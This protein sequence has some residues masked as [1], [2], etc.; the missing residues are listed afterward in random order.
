MT[1]QHIQNNTMR[2]NNKSMMGASKHM[3]V[4]FNKFAQRNSKEYKKFVNSIVERHTNFCITNIEG[5]MQLADDMLRW[6]VWD[7][8]KSLMQTAGLIREEGERISFGTAENVEFIKHIVKTAAML[9]YG[10]ICQ[11]RDLKPCKSDR[12]ELVE[13]VS[14]NCML[15]ILRNA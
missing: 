9:A 7:N 10:K 5:G 13:S 4:K 12:V 3:S 14:R 2:K 15:H 8:F 11:M 1:I 6:M